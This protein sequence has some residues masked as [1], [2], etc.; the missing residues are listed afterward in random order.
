[1]AEINLTTLSAALDN[2][3]GS[4]VSFENKEKN[5]GSKEE[6]K[7]LTDAIDKCRNL[8]FLNLAGNTLGV[9]AAQEVGKSLKKHP[10]FQRALWKD[11]FTGR[12]KTEIPIA[13]QSMGRGIIDAGAHLTVFDCSDNALGPNGM[14]GLVEL[15]SSAACFSL[16]ELKINNCG[17]GIDG[18]KMLAKALTECLKA[19]LKTPTPMKLKVFIAGR[20][21]LENKG[22]EALA[23]FF[24]Q[25][26]TLEEL[27]MPQN[28]IYH[29]GITA[30]SAALKKNQNM[31]VLN[32]NDN[33]IGSKG[34]EAL[35]DA[36]CNMHKLREINFGDCLLKTR[37]ATL[38]GEVLS[39]QHE[40]LEVLTLND[41]E[42]GPNGGLSLAF[43]MANKVNLQT[44]QLNGNH[45]GRECRELI[46]DELRRFNLENA[47][48]PMDEDDSE[49]DD[50]EGEYEEGE[51]ELEEEEE[52]DTE[53]IEDEDECA[54]D[55]DETDEAVEDGGQ[56]ANMPNLSILTPPTRV[57]ASPVETFCR[58]EKPTLAMFNAIDG[59]DR[60]AAFQEYLKSLPSDFYL[61][62][63]VFT[64]LKC[65]DLSLQSKEALAVSDALFADAFQYAQDNSQVNSVRNFFLIQ[66]CLL[67]CED[68]TFQPTYNTQAC[69]SALESAMKKNFFPSDLRGTFE[70]FL[71]KMKFD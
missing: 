15:F 18:G 50:G 69:R 26:K 51:D 56:E 23:G 59:K 47:L 27:A 19:S 54:D 53:D 11:S 10:E 7:E 12:L 39:D 60:V 8:E 57:Q 24:A 3:S 29:E 45:F 65:S 68:K 42:I 36:M 64:I 33:T 55:D 63:L 4:G 20:N 9:E 43:A 34:A 38:L 49:E 2:V 66:L 61:V 31:Q 40:A 30:L 62:Y 25:V 22:A 46:A 28:G 44:L 71:D 70:C 58:S 1:M 16:Q 17:L 67:R 48:A 14:K 52:I 5:W 6:V 21:R 41:N 13:L 35:A 37:G 32:L